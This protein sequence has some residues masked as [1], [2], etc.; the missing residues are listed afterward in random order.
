MVKLYRAHSKKYLS[1][2]EGIITNPNF[3]RIRRPRDI[4]LHVHGVLKEWFVERVGVSYREEALFCTGDRAIAEGYK[5]SNST[6]ICLEPIG[7]FS[8]CYSAVC[9][10][11]F[12]H[13]QFNWMP[14]DSS[15]EEIRADME[16]FNFNKVLN[17]GLA[18]AAETGNE[19]MVHAAS[20]RYII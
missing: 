9:K 11:L 2:C 12:A 18:E 14:R 19:V 8:I 3:D 6:V 10:D 20:F 13:C 5:R 15:E 1:G 7:S 4:P 17:G 16:S